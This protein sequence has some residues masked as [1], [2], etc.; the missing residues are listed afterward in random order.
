MYTLC[1]SLL[2]NPDSPVLYLL[3]YI[4]GVFLHWRAQNWTEYLDAVSQVQCR[5]ERS[6]PWTCWLHFYECRVANTRPA[7]LQSCLLDSWPSVC[8]GAWGYS[9]PDVGLC[10]RSFWTSWDSSHPILQPVQVPLN[11]GPALQ[12]V[13]D[14][15]TVEDSVK[16]LAKA[17]VYNIHWPPLVHSASHL[18]IKSNQVGQM[19]FAFGKSVSAL[20][21][22]PL[23]V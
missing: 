9:V 4:H 1:S 23:C 15:E 3:Q 19:W 18:V 12:C 13:N 22:F 7:F 2:T 17:E 11:N 20:P 10:I 14:N 21:S 16:G 8:T 5:G 6:P